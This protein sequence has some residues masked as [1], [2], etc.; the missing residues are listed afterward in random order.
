VARWRA[1]TRR[2][3]VR[4]GSGAYVRASH[5]ARPAPLH[6]RHGC[7]QR[8]PTDLRRRDCTRART[9]TARVRVARRRAPT[10]RARVRRGSSAYVRASP[11]ATLATPG[12]SVADH[13][14]RPTCAEAIARARGHARQG[15]GRR[16]GAHPRGAPGSGAG[17]ART[18]ARRTPRG[19]RHC[20]RARVATTPADRP[21]PNHTRAHAHTHG[22]G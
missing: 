12:A 16:G 17:Q 22:K 18:C 11:A 1:P 10:R 5:A 6:L 14:T 8:P 7:I 21:A 9:R 3:R 15:L 13:D 2:A 19:L 20:T 4:R